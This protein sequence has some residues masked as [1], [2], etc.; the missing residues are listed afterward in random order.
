[1]RFLLILF[2]LIIASCSNKKK[3]EKSINNVQKPKNLIA[4]LDTIRWTEQTLISLRDSLINI[5]GAESKE[6]DVYQ[7]EYRK[8]HKINIIKI[9]RI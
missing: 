4:T 8:S 6:A 7:E 5:Y 3:L 9:K 1:M 2:L